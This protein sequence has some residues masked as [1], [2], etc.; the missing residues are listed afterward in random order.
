MEIINHTTNWVKGDIFQGKIMLTIGILLLIGAV[1]IF[2]NNHPILKGTLIP[3]GLSVLILIGYG[4]YLAFSRPGH[5]E[6]VKTVYAENQENAIH[7]EYEKASKDNK[8]YSTLK[9]IWIVL[10]IISALLFFV[11]KT[12]YLK[13]LSIGLIGLFFVALIVDT[14][15]YYRVKPYLEALTKL[16]NL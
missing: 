12:D 11:F 15:L 1:A 16:V 3:I 10:I 5:L 4:S 2:K 14:M 7:Q 9:P 6:N 13:G 8:A